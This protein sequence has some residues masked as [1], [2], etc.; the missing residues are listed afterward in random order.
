PYTVRPFS[1]KELANATSNTERR[2]MIDFNKLLSKQRVTVEHAFGVLKMRFH[3]LRLMGYHDDVQDVWRVIE[4]L[5]ILHNLCLYH[6][7]HPEAFDEYAEVILAANEE[8]DDTDEEEEEEEDV[9]TVTGV[10][11]HGPS[12]LPRHETVA[13]LRTAGHQKRRELLDIV[14]PMANYQ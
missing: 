5:L 14:C 12:D 7:D 9:P 10:D 11:V 8:G 6:K 3:S 13:W 2:R 4:A 1:N